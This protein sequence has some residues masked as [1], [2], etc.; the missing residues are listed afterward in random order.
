MNSAPSTAVRFACR[1]ARYRCALGAGPAASAHVAGCPACQRHFHAV[2]ALDLGLR[3]SAPAARPAPAAD[4]EVRLLR[5]VCA[6]RAPA[7]A[8]AAAGQRAWLGAATAAAFAGALGLA[9]FA[10]RPAAAPAA[11]I[12]P[13]ETVAMAAAA[14][15]FSSRLVAAGI[16]RAAAAVTDNPLQHEFGAVYA[17]LR[18]AVDF[19]ALN[20]LPQSG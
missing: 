11:R 19:L 5:S 9:V 2:A 13:A 12:T 3:R 18:S 1:V 7:S 20:F 8:R 16:P 15:E 6:A 14:Q 4:F 17:D 10:G